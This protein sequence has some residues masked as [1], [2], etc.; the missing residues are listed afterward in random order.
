MNKNQSATL[1]LFDKRKNISLEKLES[2]ATFSENSDN[3]QLYIREMRTEK[4]RE[5]PK[6][7]VKSVLKAD[8]EIQNKKK[9]GTLKIYKSVDEM[10][11]EL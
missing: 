3:A 11:K 5:Y 10:F 2:F 9:N 8:K 1:P 7:L 4:N 6:K